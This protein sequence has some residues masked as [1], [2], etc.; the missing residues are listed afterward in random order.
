MCH[1]RLIRSLKRFADVFAGVH[2][3]IS[4]VFDYHGVVFRCQLTDIL[5]FLLCE[6]NPCRVV[7]VGIEYRCD[8]AFCEMTLQFLLQLFATEVIH[9]E[10]ILLVAQHVGLQWLH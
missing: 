2:A 3:Q 1:G 8:V 7:G 4:K 9:V 5:Q 10:H 6:A